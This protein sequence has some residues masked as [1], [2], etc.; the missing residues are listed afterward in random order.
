MMSPTDPQYD[1]FDDELSDEALDR[2]EQEISN[3]RVPCG[4]RR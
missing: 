2:C 3:C 4:T 1:E